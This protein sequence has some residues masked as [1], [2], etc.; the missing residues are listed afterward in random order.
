MDRIGKFLDR[1]RIFFDKAFFRTI[2]GV[3]HI[4]GFFTERCD[5]ITVSGKLE[6]RSTGFKFNGVIGGIIGKGGSG[7]AEAYAL[8][9]RKI[10]FGIHAMLFKDILKNH[11]RHAAGPSAENLLS[12]KRFPVKA[13]LRFP[14]DKEISGSLGQLCKVD[15]EI[16]FPSG[17]GVDGCL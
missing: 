17:I 2:G 16:L 14:P 10:V 12:L 13:I 9:D 5:N 7:Q 6:S 8:V 4:A 15:G 3:G 1:F 11:L